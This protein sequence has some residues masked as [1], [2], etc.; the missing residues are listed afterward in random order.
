M[1]KIT[2]FFVLPGALAL[3]ASCSG[4]GASTGEAGINVQPLRCSEGAAFCLLSCD[5]GCGSFGCA[6]S[7]IAEN[8]RLQ[9]T[10]NKAVSPASVN[11]SSFS[12]R[13]AAGAEPA[14]DLVVQGNKVIFEP[15]VTVTNGIGTFGFRRN[16][17]YILSILGGQT[18]GRHVTSTSG[19]KLSRDFTCTVRATRGILDADSLP[20]RAELVSPSNLTTA[21]LD[22]TIILRFSEI[23]DSSPFN[24]ALSA[25]T[26][27][28][29]YLRR[30]RVDPLTNERVCDFGGS[31]LLVEGVPTVTIEQFNG[32]PVTVISVRPNINLPGEA[33]VQINVTGDV[34]DVAG[35]P[36]EPRSFEFFTAPSQVGDLFFTED[37]LT[38]ARLDRPVSGGTWSN[39]ARPAQLGG[40]GRHGSFDPEVGTP[41]GNSTYVFD[42]DSQVIPGSNTFSGQPEEVR[43]GKFYFTDLTVPAGTTVRFQGSN[44]AQVFVRGIVDIQGSIV[45]DGQ[46]GAQ[47][48]AW[49]GATLT[50]I[51]GQPGRLGGAGG[52]N[53]GRG[54]DRCMNTGP[55]NNNGVIME[56][57]QPGDDVQVVQAHAYAAQA[58]GTGG[59]GSSL[60]PAAGTT[61]SLTGTYTISF[62]F[63]GVMNAGGGGGGFRG[64]G[65]DGFVPAQG[66]TIIPAANS[67][68]GSAFPLFPLP[69]AMSSLDHF[70]VGGSGGGG[71]GSHP[72][73][74]LTGQPAPWKAGAAGMGGGGAFAIRGGASINIG[75]SAFLSAQGGSGVI[76]NGDDPTTPTVELVTSPTSWGVAAPGG[77]GSGG[78]LLVQASGDLSVEGAVDV[79]GGTGSR[80][81]NVQPVSVN[82]QT[83]AGNGADGFY[84][85][86]AGGTLNVPG[87]GFQ[88]A[89]NPAENTGVLTDRDAASGSMSLWRGSGLVFPPTWVRYE[90]EVDVLGDGSD[91]RLYSDD[92][93]LPNW[94]GVADD[95]FGPVRVK[96]QGSRIN[97]TTNQ[98]IEQTEGPFRD[99]INELE[100]A[101]LNLDAATGFRFVLL[102]N[103]Q[104]FPQAV[105]R[106]IAVVARG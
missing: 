30:S 97:T 21:P 36:A 14:G 94:T 78:S 84:R 102:F 64:T 66:T 96:F 40:D 1:R 2:R 51:A 57:G 45:L 106:R 44:A 88:P 93:T 58:A 99:Y 49:S 60:V 25:S 50:P 15:S 13:T 48:R 104:L 100:G 74:A 46:D 33:C 31:P 27:I 72:F 56:N 85:F 61:A 52:G 42:T 62:V 53:G 11:N 8:Q 34:R 89:I 4:G 103:T 39:G 77:G 82:F 95:P 79:R 73:A 26:P 80:V 22:S 23:I 47:H 92:R 10:F 38:D 71:G 32:R 43:D 18:P 41:A 105:V 63:N 29:Y 12:I 37:F 75:A 69:G 91:V 59:R 81:Q 5:L 87:T 67:P 70:L 35:T 65:S 16:E 3:V 28:Q 83:E 9:F 101:S 6:V 90:L 17:T 76:I 19:D 54:G 24:S 68:G 98:P 20:P 7:D 86:E 55:T